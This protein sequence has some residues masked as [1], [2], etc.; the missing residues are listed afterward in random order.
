MKKLQLSYFFVL[1]F[2]FIAVSC[3]SDG[4]NND[5]SSD[6]QDS[7]TVEENTT[8]QMQTNYRIPSPVELY[9]YM[10]DEGALYN[11][12]MLNNV[13]NVSKYVTTKQKAINFGV[14]ASDLAYCTVYEKPQKTFLY[15]ETAKQ[16]AD[17]MGLMEGFDEIMAGRVESNMES[18]DSL[19]QI[20]N[21]AYHDACA[22]LERENKEDVLGLILAGSWIESLHI[23]FNSV[24]EFKADDPVVVRIAEQR[25]LLENLIDYQYQLGDLADPEV[26]E[27]L[28]SLQ[29]EFDMLYDNPDDVV[30][31]QKQYDAIKEK[32]AE[33]RTEYTK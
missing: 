23:A 33:L 10:N 9:L 2:L 28:E 11:F 5:N 21:D 6:N 3:A 7:L 25:F 20:S 19:Y 29:A 27:Q 16:L 15:F 1:A 18:T 12:E 17:E 24:K 13:E 8:S 31:T 22:Y 32:T 14:Y 26:V 30:I 4:D